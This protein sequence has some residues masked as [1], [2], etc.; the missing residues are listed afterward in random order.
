M[1]VISASPN[2]CTIGFTDAQADLIAHVNNQRERAFGV[3]PKDREKLVAAVRA[4]AAGGGII[5]AKVA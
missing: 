4:T 2:A 3:S 5:V 1:A